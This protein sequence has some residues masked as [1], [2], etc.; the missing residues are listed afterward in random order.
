MKGR[1]HCQLTFRIDCTYHLPN[2]KETVFFSRFLL[3]GVRA[4]SLC[5]RTRS[6][7]SFWTSDGSSSGGKYSNGSICNRE[8]FTL[9]SVELTRNLS[10]LKQKSVTTYTK[11]TKKKRFYIQSAIPMNNLFC[12][13]PEENEQESILFLPLTCID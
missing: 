9:I 2:G 12:S 11:C 1:N 7:C 10:A 8:K 13:M 6:F 5:N 4:G 3:I